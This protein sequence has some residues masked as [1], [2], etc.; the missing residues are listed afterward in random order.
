MPLL[1]LGEEGEG[2]GICIALC[3][4]STHHMLQ[5]SVSLHQSMT[6][7]LDWQAAA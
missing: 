7:V 1:D 5:H 6:V 3:P 4:A 2:F